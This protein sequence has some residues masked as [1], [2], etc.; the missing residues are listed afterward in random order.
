MGIGTTTPDM[1][2]DVNGKIRSNDDIILGTSN[3]LRW[4]DSDSFND[5][6]PSI[7]GTTDSLKFH[8]KDSNNKAMEIDGDGNVVIKGSLKAAK[9]ETTSTN[10]GD[11]VIGGKLGIGIGAIDPSAKLHVKTVD[12]NN[13]LYIESTRST[14]NTGQYHSGID[15]VTN[16]GDG[17]ATKVT[18]Y[19]ASRIISGWNS[20][21]SPYKQ[22]WIQFQTHTDD[23]NLTN[24]LIIKGGNVGIGTTEPSAKL[25]VNGDIKCNEISLSNLTIDQITGVNNDDPQITIK[26]HTSHNYNSY[27]TLEL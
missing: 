27:A 21:Q 17:D 3:F 12:A 15:F 26:R 7:E 16:D 18:T 10:S 24:D 20:G 6:H 2:L 8:T 25:D 1:K 14:G 5:N 22:S 13:I 9:Y 4:T 11:L 23:H 19:T